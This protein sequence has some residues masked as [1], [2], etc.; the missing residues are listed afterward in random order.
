MNTETSVTESQSTSSAQSVTTSI[1]RENVFFFR[2]SFLGMSEL[3]LIDVDGEGDCC[4]LACLTS[5]LNQN[6]TLSNKQ[7]RSLSTLKWSMHNMI[8]QGKH[9]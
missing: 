5:Y 6:G 8:S 1:A 7:I 2:D 4:P 3:E 9:F